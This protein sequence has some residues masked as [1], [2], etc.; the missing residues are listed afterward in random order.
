[1]QNI[2][3]RADGRYMERVYLGNIDGKTKYKCVYGASPKEVKLKAEEVRRLIKKGITTDDTT[4][5]EYTEQYLDILFVTKSQGQYDLIKARLDVMNNYIGNLKLKEIRQNDIQKAINEI[6]KTNPYTGKPSSEKTIK[7]YK[8]VIYNLFENAVDNALIERN[9]AKKITVPNIAT[10]PIERRALTD[11]ERDLIMNFEHRGQLAMVLMM[12]SGLRRG[13]AA[14]LKWSDID[15]K[16]KTISVT[17]SYDY[18]AGRL[19]LP[20]N[21]KSRIVSI[22]DKLVDFIKKK[23]NQDGYVVKSAN[24]EMMTESAWKRMFESYLC[25]LNCSILNVNKFSPVQKEKPITFT[26]HCLR[27]TFCSLMY[28]ADV[29][30]LTA[31]QQLGHS[32]PEITMKIYTHLGELKKKNSIDKLNDFLN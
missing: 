10:K 2:T 26:Y 18:K 4:A 11:Y 9:P 19:K 8:R 12:L 25:D 7:E 17:K 6:T 16:E 22:P 32:S 27:H 15:L 24:G 3:K 21:G 28:N 30:V 13:E 5:K 1:M 31:Q 14:A 29:D 23:P 20:K